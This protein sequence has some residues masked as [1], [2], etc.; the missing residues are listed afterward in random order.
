MAGLRVR[1]VSQRKGCMMK[2]LVCLTLALLLSP[3]AA[4]ALP[5]V[6]DV[7]G[8]TPEAASAALEAARFRALLPRTAISRQGAPM[9]QPAGWPRSA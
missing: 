5:A 2:P 3:L 1:P 9:P 8:T 4:L 7:V 6:G